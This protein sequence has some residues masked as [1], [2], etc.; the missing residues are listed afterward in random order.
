[1]RLG[2]SACGIQ[3][4]KTGVAQYIFGLL[5]A[6]LARHDAPDLTLFVLEN[7]APF[8]EFARG[9]AHF[10]LIS[11]RSRT[12]LKNIF[13]HQTKLPGLAKSLGLD[14]LH[15]PTY[16]RLVWSK[17]CPLTATIHDLAPFHI[18]GKYDPARMLYG[19]VIARLLARRQDAII[20][21]SESTAR[22]VKR[23]F[24]IP[25]E[26]VHMIHNGLDHARFNP[27]GT[28][29]PWRSL[30]AAW[31]L[32]RPFII[33][34]SRLEHPGKN[35]V[36][37]IDAFSRFKL[38]TKSD[39]LLAFAG[40]D[41]HGADVIHK[42]AAES[43]VRTDIRFLGFVPD[44]ALPSLYRSAAAAVYPSLFEGFGFPPAEA[45]ACGCPVL[46]SRRGALAEVVGAAAGVLEPEQ[47]A[48]MAA[49]LERIA[50][51][52]AWR[53]Q[54]RRAG[55]LNAKR[56]DW[57]AN[58]EQVLR[59]YRKLLQPPIQLMVRSGCTKSGSPI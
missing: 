40:S 1:M 12:P 57:N 15:V 11:E 56:F 13:W 16:R 14:V 52:D 7:D 8:L 20:A 22:D 59:C 38:A 49:A 4:G 34:L 18:R 26:R 54:L 32:D 6:L 44:D 37:L 58:A 28:G 45:M 33:Y 19:R 35:H 47:P 31:Q 50:Q 17:R 23:F 5:R 48:Q 10:H 41:W 21:V 55:F 51:D 9:K 29:D 36:R 24:S 25:E 3:G 39:W 46:S 2:F 43:P 27:A 30:D 42:A 53:E